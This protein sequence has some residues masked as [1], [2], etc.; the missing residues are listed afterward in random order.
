[1]PH[2]L[3]RAEFLAA[4]LGAGTLPRPAAANAADLGQMMWDFTVGY[5]RRLD[6]RRQEAYAAIQTPED[7][8]ALR[9]RVR[10]RLAAMWGPMPEERT[11]LNPR[12]LGSIER[13]GYVVEKIIYESRPKSYVTANLYRP[14]ATEGRLPAVIFPPGHADDGKAYR[15][16]QRFAIVM[17][18]SGFIVL[19]WD[20]I[21]QGE[22]V[23]LWDTQNKRPLVGLG[24]KEHR[25]LGQQCYLLGLNLM[26]YRV[27]DSIRAIDYLESRPDVDRERIAM[28]GNSG[29]GMETLQFAPFEPRIK[30]AAP[31][32][33]VAGFRRKTEALLI[34]DPEQILYGTLRY[35]IEHTEL[36]ASFAPRPLMIGAATRDYVPIQGARETYRAV[37]KAYALVKANEKA[38]LI[39]TDDVHGLNKDLREATARWFSHW[40]SDGQ[41]SEQDPSADVLPAEELRC[42]ASG[43]VATSFETPA[44]V[45]S[46]NRE[47]ADKIAAS[48]TV[49]ASAG[50]FNIFRTEIN[51]QVRFVSRVGKAK[52]EPG[53]FV[54]DRVFD[55]ATFAKGDALVV[56]DT[57]KDEPALRRSVIDPMLA[58][59]YR[60]TVLDLRGWGETAPSMPQF[61]VSFS[62]DEFFAYR[63]LEIGRPLLGQR[64]RDLLAAAPKRTTHRKWTVVGVG[65]GALVA[66]HAAVIDTRISRLITIGGL[67][68]YRSLVDDPQATQPF[69]SYLPSV[70]DAYDIKEIYAA[71]APRPVMVIN[72]RDS[73]SRPVQRVKA[74]AQLD[75]TAQVYEVMGGPDA[76]QLKTELNPLQIRRAVGAWMETKT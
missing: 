70:I 21:G 4:L 30:A 51:R 37:S 39:E 52:R 11:S 74:W 40:L 47:Y 73:Q 50:E 67:L 16:Y 3:T 38:S 5:I 34:A 76:F 36:L 56:S 46:F 55:P 13:P 7:L 22:R 43:Q 65:A 35:G 29:G 72:P 53:V 61:E 54:P 14:K 62:W 18:R 59:G 25:V 31:M 23:Q 26:Q 69:S 33:A 71:L 60:V 2:P 58:V 64:M 12:Q 41:I 9:T 66:A 49:P 57:G 20:P 6:E 19:A 48:R 27:W 28:A 44:T 45:F 24:T 1:M 15:E 32:C 68:S 63:A 17:A 10:S 75:W 42:T 8:D